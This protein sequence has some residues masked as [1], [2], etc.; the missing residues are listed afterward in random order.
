MLV[1]FMSIFLVSLFGFFSGTLIG[2]AGIG[3]VI[4]VPLLVY[5]AGFDIHESIA[6]SVTSFVVSGLIGS[7]VYSA[8]GVVNWPQLG[9]LTVGAFPGAFFGTYLLP[10]LDADFLK[11]FIASVLILTAYRQIASMHFQLSQVQR[12]VNNWEFILVGFVT[13]SLSVLSGTGGPL[14]LVPILTFLSVPIIS[15]IGLSQAIQVPIAVF[16]T[17]GNGLAGLIKWEIVLPIS[18][19]LALG[20]FFG[21]TTSKHLPVEKIKKLVAFLLLGSGIYMVITLIAV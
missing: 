14:V 13:G 1:V 11:F 2:L 9:Y 15:V 5:G 3:G 20:T 16:A 17:I 4:L 12:F 21:A 18:L 10:K 19:G 6:A 7:V 8:R